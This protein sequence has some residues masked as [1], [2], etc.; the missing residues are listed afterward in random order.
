MRNDSS[1][2]ITKEISF[3][4]K[5]VETKKESLDREFNNWDL[6]ADRVPRT[7]WDE[8]PYP[9]VFTQMIPCTPCTWG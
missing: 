1:K 9:P 2:Q 4:L 8:S 5:A 3:S 6:D 7:R